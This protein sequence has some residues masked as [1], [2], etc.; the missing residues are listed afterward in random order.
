[1]NSA[2]DASKPPRSSSHE[3]LRGRRIGVGRT[4]EIFEWPR[5][6]VLKLYV[7]GYSPGAT[8][9]E[10]R[11]ARAARACG[12]ST[13]DVFDEVTV[14]GRH[15]VVFERV[16]GPTMLASVATGQMDL[17]AAASQFAELHA[18]IHARTA[19]ELPPFS[20]MLAF[21]IRRA[22]GLAPSLLDFALSRL[23]SSPSGCSVCHGDFHPDNVLMSERGA[24]AI[25]WMNGGAGDP[26]ADVAR[27]IFLMG[28]AHVPEHMPNRAEITD[29]RQRFLALYLE[30]YCALTGVLMREVETWMPVIFAA[31]FGESVPE[32]R[33][34]LT[35]LLRRYH[36]SAT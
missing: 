1:M 36:T 15:G 25:D 30:R 10:L 21:N 7:R 35:A 28:H 33:A 23:P 34:H 17:A 8:S 12:V 11:V 22:E 14:E 6:R 4:A 16:T 5:N 3:D 19:N 2:S 26:A 29:L 20:E 27:T 13:P 31:R 9:R 24:V 18:Q 32:E